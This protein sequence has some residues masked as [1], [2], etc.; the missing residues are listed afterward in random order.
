MSESSFFGKTPKGYFCLAQTCLVPPGVQA[1]VRRL[2]LS[3]GIPPP[4]LAIPLVWND[5]SR[6]LA[7][8]HKFVFALLK[9]ATGIAWFWSASRSKSRAIR[10]RW[11]RGYG[12]LTTIIF[13]NPYQKLLKIFCFKKRN[14]TFRGLCKIFVLC[15]SAETC[16]PFLPAN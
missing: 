6:P 5:P 12:S 9:Q 2:P 15:Y 1:R 13:M 7:T 3:W 14:S 4:G 10:N 11:I 8:E 16:M